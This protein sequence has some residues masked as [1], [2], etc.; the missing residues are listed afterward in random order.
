MG[1]KIDPIGAGDAFFSCIIKEYIKNDMILDKSKFEK[2]YDISSKLTSKVVEQMGARGYLHSLYKIKEKEDFCTCK[3]FELVLRKQIK[4]CNININNLEKRIFNAIDSKADEKIDLVGFTSK[5]NYIFIGTGGSLA[6]AKF[7]S[8]LINDIYGS[9]TYALTPRDVVYRN[10][11]NINKILLFSYSGTT[12]DV[13]ESAKDFD[14]N[15]VILIT[16]G[17]PK[18]VSEK[19]GYN[20]ENIISYATS[21]SKGKERGFLSF[22]GAIVPAT[23]FLKWYLNVKNIEIDLKDFIHNSIEYWNDYF[24]N[25]FKNVDLKKEFKNVVNIFTGDYTNCASADIES[26]LIESGIYNCLIHEK[27]NFSHGR[28]IN[29]ENLDNKTS[30]YFKQ[31]RTAEYETKLLD[32]LQNGNNLIV[33]SKY[34]GILCEY[35]LLIASQYIIYYIGKYLDIDVSKPKYSE[36]AMKIYFYKGSLK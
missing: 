21:K 15:S 27:K 9:N 18:K 28:F 14:K 13:L 6:G 26:K 25:Y 4:R 34:D 10:N 32:Y 20:K 1:E 11:K 16:K 7:A 35:D 24:D 12:N 17:N 22:E 30:I 36:N 23:L 31:S 5:D 29:Y 8:I 19:T 3:K 2:W 33:E